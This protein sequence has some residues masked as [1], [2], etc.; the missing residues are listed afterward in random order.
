M[1]LQED[2]RYDL[3]FIDEKTTE[4]LEFVLNRFLKKRFDWLNSIKLQNVLVNTM[5]TWEG[6][7]VFYSGVLNV[8]ENWG[9]KKWIENNGDSEFPGNEGF[10][11]KQYDG[12]L[13]KELLSPKNISEIAEVFKTVFKGLKIIDENISVSKIDNMLVYFDEKEMTL[14]E[15][16]IRVLKEETKINPFLRRRLGMLDYEVEYRLSAIYRPDN[17]CQYKNGDE[18]VEVVMEEA[19]DSMYWNYFANTDDNSEEWVN[20][21]YEMVK[22]IRDKYGDEIRNYYIDNCGSK[23]KEMGEGELTEKCW[24]G[25]TQKGMKTMFG[26]R[27]PNCVKKTKK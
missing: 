15:H 4:R 7:Y 10:D 23:K 12:L 13:L 1:N 6:I 3:V 14:K 24:K 27:Y 16:I 20:I 22:Y 18:L 5:S 17:I 8:D 2:K 21:Y 25:Y 11:Y 19:I 9:R 26:K